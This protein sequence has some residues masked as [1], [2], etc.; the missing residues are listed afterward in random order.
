MVEE[1]NTKVVSMLIL[2]TWPSILKIYMFTTTK[3]YSCYT[4]T[5]RR[6]PIIAV[7]RK[8]ASMAPSM[9][10]VTHLIISFLLRGTAVTRVARVIPSPTG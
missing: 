5:P 8:E 4:S 2:K 9:A 3:K 10:L 7:V 6:V 1:I